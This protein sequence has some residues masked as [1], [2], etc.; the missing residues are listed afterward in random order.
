MSLSELIARQWAGYSGAHAARANLLIH[1]GAV[2]LFLLGNVA[3]LVGLIQ[4]AP[5]QIIGGAAAM[6]VGLAL[7]GRGHKFESVPPEPFKGPTNA[8][9]RLLFEQW[10]TF[11]RFVLSG[12][13]LEA[14][15][16]TA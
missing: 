8:I 4:V 12:G 9:T 2:P 11:P 13:W 7:Q 3:L 10:V 15:Q 5:A 14:L 1:I 16:R 6:G